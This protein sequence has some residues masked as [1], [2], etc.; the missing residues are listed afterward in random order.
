MMIAHPY[1][2]SIG[3]EGDYRAVIIFSQGYLVIIVRIGFIQRGNPVSVGRK[4]S[5]ETVLLSV[6]LVDFYFCAF[7][8]FPADEITNE[9]IISCF[10]RF[11]GNGR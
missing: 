9:D 11:T 4:F 8:G 6:S 7:D 10:S 3:R 2:Q 5:C 1:G